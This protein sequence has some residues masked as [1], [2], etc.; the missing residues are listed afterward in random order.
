VFP[1]K[2]I[3][4]GGTKQ[5][6]NSSSN[7]RDNNSPQRTQRAQRKFCLKDRNIF[8]SLIFNVYFDFD[9][10]VS[11]NS[12]PSVAKINLKE[13]KWHVPFVKVLM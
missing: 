6:I 2:G 3:R 9:C 7:G 12:V 8:R 1:P 11:V 4:P 5:R 10:I 13:L